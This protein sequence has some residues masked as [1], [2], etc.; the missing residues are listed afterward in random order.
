MGEPTKFKPC[1]YVNRFT[2]QQSGCGSSIGWDEEDECWREEGSNKIHTKDRCKE[3]R[4]S[5][6]QAQPQQQQ[7]RSESKPIESY[8]SGA[9]SETKNPIAKAVSDDQGVVRTKIPRLDELERTTGFMWTMVKS[10]NTKLDALQ[11]I[12]NDQK[13]LIDGIAK[14][15]ES[16]DAFIS[17]VYKAL[18]PVEDQFKRAD[19]PSKS[20]DDPSSEPVKEFNQL[21]KAQH[22]E[23]QYEDEGMPPPEEEP[24]SED[25]NIPS[26]DQEPD[27]DEE[28]RQQAEMQYDQD[29]EGG[30]QG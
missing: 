11:T 8:S 4:T 2:N 12:K 9:E 20:F 3:I 24:E 21:V 14:W 23:V 1:Q 28:D 7:T 10:M 18:V 29:K 13:A 15:K 17:E 25:D 19:R 5:K 27:Q 26:S 22:G 30:I 6:Q 16:Q